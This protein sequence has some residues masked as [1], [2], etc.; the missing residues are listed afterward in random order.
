M[1][2]W[3]RDEKAFVCGVRNKYCYVCSKKRSEKE[4]PPHKCIL[5]YK[6]PS[7]GMEQ[8]I[9]VEGFNCSKE[10][11]K[12]RYKFII[13][14][15]DLSVYSR[16]VERCRYGRRVEKLEFANHIGRCYTNHLQTLKV[17]KTFDKTVGD[18]LSST[19]LYHA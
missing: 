13:G 1:H 19:I 7:T 5:N 9:I 10:Q 6:G 17:G 14:D 3:R 18:L 12:L 16:V 2:Y 11:H 4:P 8:D 15:G